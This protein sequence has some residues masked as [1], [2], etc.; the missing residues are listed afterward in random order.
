MH[1]YAACE[2][3]RLSVR[4]PS[5]QTEYKHGDRSDRTVPPTRIRGVEGPGGVRV[6]GV[7]G[8]GRLLFVPVRRLVLSQPPDVTHSLSRR[9][10]VRGYP[11]E[12]RKGVG[13]W[14]F[15]IETWRQAYGTSSS[16]GLERMNA[17]RSLGGPRCK[18]DMNAETK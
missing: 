13:Q 5:N 10:V 7:E 1:G 8:P 16:L 12:S 17:A 3:G 18:L 11:R 2:T 6:G 9:C 14:G 15:L 4:H